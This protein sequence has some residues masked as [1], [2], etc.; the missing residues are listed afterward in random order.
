MRGG[1]NLH[2]ENNGTLLW[3]VGK[4][5]DEFIGLEKVARY[6]NNIVEA[7]TDHFAKQLATGENI[8]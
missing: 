4:C 2:V 1:E 7:T 8:E 3:V 5:V 6:E